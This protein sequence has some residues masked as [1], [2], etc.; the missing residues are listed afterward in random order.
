MH[1]RICYDTV[2]IIP[3]SFLFICIMCTF[4]L[5]NTDNVL[6]INIY[7]YKR[8]NQSNVLSQYDALNVAF[9]PYKLFPK[10][11]I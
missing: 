6:I 4:C 2:G 5:Y 9:V 3:Y 11:G 8:C 7:K 1:M 10:K